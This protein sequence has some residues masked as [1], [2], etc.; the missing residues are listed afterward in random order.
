MDRK[1][2]RDN[3]PF[4][5]A[6]A[7][8]MAQSAVVGVVAWEAGGAFHYRTVP[9]NSLAVLIGLHDL[10]GLAIDAVRSGD[11]ADEPDPAD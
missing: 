4:S 7:E 9:D 10:L 1:H 3:G 8:A 5:F 2:A 11:D 6:A